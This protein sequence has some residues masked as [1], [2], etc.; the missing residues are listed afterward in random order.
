MSLVEV[1]LMDVVALELN[2][3]AK[4]LQSKVRDFDL[5]RERL[6]LNVYMDN[7]KYMGGLKELVLP[8]AHF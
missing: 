8:K 7:I 4:Y 5:M 6:K 3:S 2:W 1:L